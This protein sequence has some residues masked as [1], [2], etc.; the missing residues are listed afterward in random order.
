[1]GP[2]LPKSIMQEGELQEVMMRSLG[3]WW[4]RNSFLEMPRLKQKDRSCSGPSQVNSEWS[5]VE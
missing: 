2:S 5:G 3:L 4:D 1:M